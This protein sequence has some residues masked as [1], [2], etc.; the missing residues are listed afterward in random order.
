MCIP[1]TSGGS[2]GA[3]PGWTAEV[4]PV[5]QDSIFWH[6]GSAT[7]WH[8]CRYHETHTCY[9]RD[10]IRS[11]NQREQDIVN[12]RFAQFILSHNDRDFWSEVKRIR[13]HRV[14][15][16]N[17]VDNI[18]NAPDIAEFFFADKYEDLYSC[19]AFCA[20]D[21]DSA[22]KDIT[23]LCESAVTVIVRS[24]LPTLRLLFIDFS[25]GRVMVTEV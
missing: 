8:S 24:H 22:K 7:E 17:V 20:T 9:V 12:E 25:Q 11:V 15:S 1:K 3:V 4:E 13:N 18:S 21:M 19:V 2:S 14:S 10:T 16:S 5:R 6:V 23:L